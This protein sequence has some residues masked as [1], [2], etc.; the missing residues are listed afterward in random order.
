MTRD[1]CAITRLVHLPLWS[2]GPP[3]P[4]SQLSATHLPFSHLGVPLRQAGLCDLTPFERRQTGQWPFVAPSTFRGVGRFHKRRPS[5][6]IAWSAPIPSAVARRA[7]KKEVD[8]IRVLASKST[9][10]LGRGRSV[11]ASHAGHD[12]LVGQWSIR[13]KLRTVHSTCNLERQGRIQARFA[14]TTRR[15]TETKQKKHTVHQ[16]LGA[17]NPLHACDLFALG[18][19]SSQP[20]IG[21]R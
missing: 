6:D 18:Q 17:R 21:L 11:A 1:K 8:K 7:N 13:V 2:R 14:W 5:S 16:E 15:D 19:G 10:Y 4:A 9:L 20:R 3:I 12:L